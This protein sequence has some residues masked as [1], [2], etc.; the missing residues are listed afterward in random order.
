MSLFSG[1]M[2]NKSA[3]ADGEQLDA[4]SKDAPPQGDP[5]QGDPQ[6]CPDQKRVSAFGF[7]HRATGTGTSTSARDSEIEEADDPSS[8]F[9]FI[10]AQA[11]H[12]REP[13]RQATDH[14][15]IGPPT[16]SGVDVDLDFDMDLDFELDPLRPDL[17]S[18]ESRRDG[19]G[20]EL[21]GINFSIDLDQT[22]KNDCHI[23]SD[24]TALPVRQ[25]KQCVAE[26]DDADSSLGP[27]AGELKDSNKSGVHGNPNSDIT[28]SKDEH[29]ENAG[30]SRDSRN[31]PPIN[32]GGV[33]GTKP[34]R[35]NTLEGHSAN[36]LDAPSSQ[37][38][39]IS[40]TS[41]ECLEERDAVPVVCPSSRNFYGG[42]SVSRKN[43]DRALDGVT[44]SAGATSS[45]LYDLDLDISDTLEVLQEAQ[46][47]ADQQFRLSQ[48]DL[49]ERLQ[50][51]GRQR[52]LAM[53]GRIK[54]Q[55]A[56][57]TLHR[58]QAK[59]V[60]EEDYQTA[61]SLLKEC[62]SLEKDLATIPS[63]V[64]HREVPFQDILQAARDAGRRQEKQETDWVKSYRDLQTQQEDFLASLREEEEGG[65]GRERWHQLE[66]QRA[67]LERSIGHVQL[68][69]EH[70]ERKDVQLQ[71][72]IDEKTADLRE[73]K[74]VY[75]Q[76]KTAVQMEI[77]EL[78]ERLLVLRSEETTLDKAI[79]EQD[80]AIRAAREEFNEELAVIG[81]EKSDLGEQETR[82]NE[83][84]LG[85]DRQE[86]ALREKSQQF[87]E[88]VAREEDLLCRIS[89]SLEAIMKAS[90]LRHSV[91]E[92]TIFPDSPIQLE[93]S[94]EITSLRNSLTK[95]TDKI[96]ST[97]AG[98]LSNQTRLTSL[99]KQVMDTED[100]IATLQGAKQLAV[101]SR[102]FGEAKRLA[103]EIRVKM[104]EG[105]SHQAKVEEVCEHLKQEKAM[106]EDL[107]EKAE[108][109]KARVLDAEKRWEVDLRDYA[110]L[111]MSSIEAALEE[112]N[113][114]SSSYGPSGTLS[115]QLL[116]MERQVC[117]LLVG[118]LSERHGLDRPPIVEAVIQSVEEYEAGQSI[119]VHRESEEP[120]TGSLDSQSD[121][122]KA[123]L[124][125]LEERLQQAVDNENYDDADIFCINVAVPNAFKR[126][127]SNSR[128]RETGDSTHL[129]TWHP[130]KKTLNLLRN[131]M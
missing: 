93:P 122:V 35:E 120:G 124:Q 76:K 31:L 19:R 81:R 36:T 5:P 4:S 69:R 89:Q 115:V 37:F 85:L 7:L 119:L 96:Q 130:I 50:E 33:V 39:F 82:L 55:E 101:S 110:L 34:T 16:G 9:G 56:L 91:G 11:S 127:L 41:R 125:Q 95:T 103:E 57:F 108:E 113:I 128:Q 111:M 64:L 38:G 117:G 46:A 60:S 47:A 48:E 30:R 21:E 53:H 17:Q 1:M 123:E 105:Q 52:V 61:E 102:N 59:A 10:T 15:G 20:F 43:D 106:V 77:K 104:V 62:L 45:S 3:E 126:E 22:D 112:S 71:A 44:G 84:K 116:E 79:D 27:T 80:R 83:E 28:A 6:S 63:I 114:P 65:G 118:W 94:E 109:L 74:K 51:L 131:E 66:K 86:L 90:E 100:Y 26:V 129:D 13:V 72:R 73:A 67:E 8:K 23:G 14:Q 42:E 70:V 12:S 92:A 2:L 98:I 121:G 68:D 18:S 29:T 32:D 25:P 99:K 40:K 97:S 75:G 88:T 78:E 54:K 107:Q 24:V 49:M 58:Q 87:E